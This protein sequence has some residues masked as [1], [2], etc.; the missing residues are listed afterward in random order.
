MRKERILQD[1]FGL[2]DAV[3]EG[4][5]FDDE[6]G[7]IVVAVRPRAK[8]RSRCGRCAR[9]SPRYDH[10]EG[11]RWRALDLGTTK[12]FLEGPA[13]RVSCRDHGNSSGNK[14][15]SIVKGVWHWWQNVSEDFTNGLTHPAKRFSPTPAPTP[16]SV[17]VPAA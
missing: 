14:A 10:G 8:S 4:V 6:A 11:R 2:G 7:A 16:G 1:A 13:P 5:D 3:V 17:P 9:R 12:V 15:V